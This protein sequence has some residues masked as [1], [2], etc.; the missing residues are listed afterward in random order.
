[1]AEFVSN[2]IK[3]LNGTPISTLKSLM[4]HS[5]IQTTSKFYLQSTDANEE[6]ACQALD[7]IM[8]VLETDTEMTLEPPKHKKSEKPSLPN[9][10]SHQKLH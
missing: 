1:M 2:F 10:R 6:R 4:G 5:D 9:F 7:R 8:E 3:G